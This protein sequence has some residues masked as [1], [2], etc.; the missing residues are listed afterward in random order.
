MGR[1][2]RSRPKAPTGSRRSL[3]YPASGRWTATATLPERYA[4]H[5]DAKSLGPDGKPCRRGTVSLLHR[6]PATAGETKL[7]GKESNR[8][9]GRFTGL[10]TVDEL[11][12]RLV[13]Y[14]DDDGWRRIT[15]P[16]LQAI[17][18]PEGRRGG[19]HQRAAAA[20]HLEG[21]VDAPS[22]APNAVGGVQPAIVVR[23]FE[24][25]GDHVRWAGKRR[26]KTSTETDKVLFRWVCSVW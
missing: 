6:R 1:P 10:L 19:R 18:C 20:G 12:E 2:A 11:D 15:L 26:R 4:A 9:E 17:E 25:P 3:A 21:E 22:R 24:S 8:L 5:P 23:R 16:K 13:T 7:I 14:L